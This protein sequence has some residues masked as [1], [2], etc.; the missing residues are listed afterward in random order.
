MTDP[1]SLA[2]YDVAI[3]GG[4]PVGLSLALGLARHGVR[5]VLLERKEG[6]SRW[7]KAPGIHV[8]T[9][10]VFRQWGVE[11]L[12][13]EAGTL[14]RKVRIHS[15]E[16]RLLASI[17]F[18][19]LDAEA[20]RPGLLVLEQA[21]TEKLLLDAVRE[22]GLCDLRFATEAVVLEQHD[23]GVRLSCRHDGAHSTVDAGFVVGCDGA[24][25]FTRKALG[26]SF[27]GFTYAVRPMLADV[28]IDDRRDE[29]GWPRIWNGHGGLTA[30]IRLET[31]LWRL[32]RLERGEPDAD[33]TVP[34]T[35]ISEHVRSTLGAGPFTTEWASRF[36]I[37]LRSAPTF[38]IGRVLL[39]G[40]AAHIHSPAGG[41]GMNAGIQDAHNLA[42][43]LAAAIRGGD[44]DALL[45]SYDVERRSVTVEEVS[46]YADYATRIFLQSPPAL[47]APAFL[48]L[49]L[50]L[51][52]APIR[53]A[54]LRRLSMIAL[55]YG[56]SPLL[57]PEAKAVGRR[58]PN[59][60]L[61]SAGGTMIRL[62]DLVPNE[63]FLIHVADADEPIRP[64]DGHV[65][66]IGSG[67]YQEPSDMLRKMIDGHDGWILVRPDLHIAWLGATLPS[68][69][70]LLR[71]LGRPHL[72]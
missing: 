19:V 52:V 17:D 27:D 43:K 22:T 34:E 48:I 13:L 42:W 25:S 20:D 72:Q 50:L 65:I 61:H 69:Q 15:P 5:S 37:H 26:L 67:A 68:R 63:A 47:R 71:S 38:R 55:G 39:A 44:T 30:A 11:D 8:R 2:P 70:V 12:F 16:S 60:L 59:P 3:V 6:T 49:R 66:R 33:A 7:S 10:E 4:G 62:Y 56:P 54:M 18:S 45:D 41:L 1:R 24:G 14:L 23:G 31:G 29:L 57:R 58:L 36:R 51:A 64:L 32:I 21:R 28:R 46:S 35:E 40:D 53:K 9:R